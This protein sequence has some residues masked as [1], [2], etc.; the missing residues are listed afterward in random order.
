ML[1]E[2]LKGKITELLPAATFEEGGEWITVLIEPTDW[3]P[4][5]KSTPT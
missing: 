3:L 2:E 4:S 5:A 1:N